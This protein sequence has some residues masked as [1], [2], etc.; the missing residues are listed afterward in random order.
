MPLSMVPTLVPVDGANFDNLISFTSSV[1]T[2]VTQHPVEFGVDVSD[3]AQ[4]G[5]IELVFSVMITKTPIGLPSLMT[6]ELAQAW[7]ERNEGKQVNISATAGIF[8]GFILSRVSYDQHPGH[9][10]WNCT[11]R[12]IRTAAAVSV[13]IPPRVPN[14]AVANGLASASS[15]GAQ[16][17]TPVP[18]PPASDISVVATGLALVGG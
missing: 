5:P 18:P 15:S 2:N 6:I 13:P 12:Q 11:A 1:A 7:F 3:H 9:R 14:P 17:P 16:P 4:V 8:A 10:I